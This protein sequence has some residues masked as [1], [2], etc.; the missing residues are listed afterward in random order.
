[1]ERPVMRRPL[2]CAGTAVGLLAASLLAGCEQTRSVD[3]YLEH[4][5][6][7]RRQVDDCRV[8]AA[9]GANCSNAMAAI[10][11][12]EKRKFEETRRKTLEEAETGSWMAK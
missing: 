2:R 12:I 10:R 5:P 8:N 3:Y 1:M 7:A 4:E 9:A 11:E 6:E